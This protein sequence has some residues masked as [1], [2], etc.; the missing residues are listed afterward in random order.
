MHKTI[1]LFPLAL[2]SLAFSA[3]AQEV[4]RVLFCM[5]QCYGVDANGDRVPVTKG[6]QLAPGL[7]LE[8]GPNSY[9]QVK[10]GPDAAFGMG[11][12]AR[13]RFDPR[14]PDREV[15][16]L[17]QGRVRVV[18]GEAIGRPATRPVEL[19]TSEGAIVLRSADIEVKTPPKT[20]DV[21]PAPTLVKLNIGD[22]RLGGLP[23]TRDA[24]YG[25]V[26]GKIL[27]RAIPIGDIALPALRRDPAPAGPT[28]ASERFASPPI[29]A[30]PVI[31]LP[32]SEPKPFLTPVA[33]SP[34]IISP[35]LSRQ[36]LSTSLNISGTSVT[37]TTLLVKEPVV[38]ASTLILAQPI[39][40]STG[41]TSLNT[42]A[43]KIQTEPTMTTTTSTTLS[44]TITLQPTLT[45]TTTTTTTLSP[46]F[47]RRF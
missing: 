20:G 47:V 8:T 12:S 19:R 27:D 13:V 41:T 31:N 26:D 22:A 9:M 36:T 21:T 4:P 32:V 39:T 18:D 7:R 15:L 38:T 43:T 34:A 11:E 23:V 40:T 45:T 17:D 25:I 14:V 37:G 29:L 3:A 5:G 28:A 35:E 2:L 44:T 16:I 33:V 10:L 1:A 30:L 42:I 6:T 24:V 46:N